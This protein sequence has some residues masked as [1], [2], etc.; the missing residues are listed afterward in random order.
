MRKRVAAPAVGLLLA[1]FVAGCGGGSDDPPAPNPPSG[2]PP[3]GNQPPSAP[4]PPPAAT[5]ANS[6]AQVKADMTGTH[7]AA[8]PQLAGSDYYANGPALRPGSPGAGRVALG[9]YGQVYVASG[10]ASANARVQLR[11]LETYAYTG[12]VWKRVQYSERVKGAFYSAGYAGAGQSASGSIRNEASGGISVKPLANRLFRFWPES[13]LTATL[14]DPNTVEAVFTTV[15]ARLIRD[16]GSVVPDASAKLLVNTA[17]EWRDQADFQSLFATEVPA[18]AEFVGNDQIGNGKLRL[19]TDQ[20]QAMN[21]HSGSSAQADALASGSKSAL[22]NSTPFD[23]PAA[24][25][26][27]VIGDSISEGGFG[28]D[29]YRRE[30]WNG[31]VSRDDKPLVDFVGKRRGVTNQGGTCQPT[32]SSTNVA[33]LRPEFDLDHQAYWGWCVDTVNNDL[34][35]RLAELNADGRT[36]DIALVHLGTNDLSQQA[37]AASSIRADLDSLITTLRAANPSIR[38]LLARIIPYSG[39][40]AQVAALNAEIASLAA[41]RSTTGSPVTPVDQ[42]TGFVVGD[43]YDGFHPDDGGETKMA[44]RWLEALAAPLP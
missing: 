4:P 11:N 6:V 14:V 19:V 7:E 43:L 37:Q 36:P 34:P 20:W 1:L 26:L 2:P 21:F 16:D 27:I 35:Q 24:K 31:L 25:R 38:I 22:A 9:G 13:G 8:S 17:A 12:G 28:H 23:V 15:Q 32:S 44:N 39:G 18:A 33:P 5:S 40:E 10:H 30:L 42:A 29:S 3:S 41:Q